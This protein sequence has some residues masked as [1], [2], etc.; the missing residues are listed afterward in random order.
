M[1]NGLR[2]AKIAS[3]DQW[4][5]PEPRMIGFPNVPEFN[6]KYELQN[7]EDRARTDQHA[8]HDADVSAENGIGERR[9]WRHHALFAFNLRRI[10][11]IRCTLVWKQ[12]TITIT[13]VHSS[14]R[15]PPIMVSPLFHRKST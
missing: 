4:R 15:R 12:P 7:C 8:D 6:A 13:H 10:R 5:H 14:A 9:G 1:M 2:P 3:R 11:A